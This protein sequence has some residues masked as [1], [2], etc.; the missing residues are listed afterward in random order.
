MSLWS[1]TSL[2]VLRIRQVFFMFNCLTSLP[3][4]PVHTSLQTSASEHHTLSYASSCIPP[5]AGADQE[6]T[7]YHCSCPT[8]P[9][10]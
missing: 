9:S 5:Q 10:I 1:L 7:T 8:T 3:F 2:Q 4:L 6:H